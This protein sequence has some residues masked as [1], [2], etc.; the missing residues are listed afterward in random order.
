[1]TQVQ[2]RAC[3]RMATGASSR[4]RSRA[5][6]IHQM[7]E[8]RAFK[9]PTR[10]EHEAK[11]RRLSKPRWNQTSTKRHHNA[12]SRAPSQQKFSHEPEG[13]PTEVRP[14]RSPPRPHQN[15]A[16]TKR[17]QIACQLTVVSRTLISAAERP[18]QQLHTSAAHLRRQTSASLAVSHSQASHRHATRWQAHPPG[19]LPPPRQR[20]RCRLQ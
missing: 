19:T 2:A 17:K 11:H 16:R 15:T 13:E 10:T 5:M 1:M 9:T 6:M 14:Y 20:C 7:N 12:K 4:A 8:S 18:Q 3:A